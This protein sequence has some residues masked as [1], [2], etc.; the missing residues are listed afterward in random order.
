MSSRVI[1]QAVLLTIAG[2]CDTL[3]RNN[4]FERKKAMVFTPNNAS[5]SFYYYYFFTVK[6]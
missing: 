3:V 2:R 6:E 1:L 4:P 5:F